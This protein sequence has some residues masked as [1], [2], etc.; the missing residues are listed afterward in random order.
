MREAVPSEPSSSKLIWATRNRCRLSSNAAVFTAVMHF[1]AFIEAGESVKVPE[2]YFANNSVGTFN[3]LRNLV[4]AQ[5][6]RFVF[7][8]TA[9]V[10]G[11]PVSVPIVEEH[12]LRPT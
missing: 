10:Y 12:P 8:S 9:A 6:S 7:S 1:A 2:K 3:L 4:K 11:E 5:V